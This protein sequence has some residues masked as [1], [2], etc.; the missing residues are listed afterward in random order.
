MSISKIPSMVAFPLGAKSN[1]LLYFDVSSDP[2]PVD[3]KASYVEME[4]SVSNLGDAGYHNLVIG[5]DG[6]MY[7][8]GSAFFRQAKLTDSAR[9]KIQ[10]LNFV[11]VLSENLSHYQKSANEVV[12]DSVFSGVG[13]RAPT[14][15][16]LSVFNNSYADQS[17]VI[18]ATLS[19]LYP[20]TVGNS[21]VM[22]Q[23]GDMEFRYLLE[24]SM[25]LLMRA[26][27]AGVYEGDVSG[28]IAYDFA[29][30]AGNGTVFD[31][32]ITGV[33]T[34]IA[35]GNFVEVSYSTD[36]GD[37]IDTQVRK[38]AN[39]AGFSGSTPQAITLDLALEATAEPALT[40]ISMKI[41]S[42]SHKI[43][44]NALTTTGANS[45]LTLSTGVNLA[46]NTD[47]NVGTKCHIHYHVYNTSTGSLSDEIVE[48]K[49]LSTVNAPDA[50]VVS[51]VLDSPI[52]VSANTDAVFVS[53]VP[54]YQNLPNAE[55]SV[56]GA[57][58]V[59]YRR[60]IKPQK[61]SKLLVGN[62]ESTS[63]Q[64]VDGLN[65]FLYTYKIKP[66]CFNAYVMTPSPT[67]LVAQRQGIKE[68]LMS[69]DNVPLTSIY[70][71]STDSSV[72]QDN[73]VRVFQNCQ[74]GSVK[75]QNLRANRDREVTTEV[76]VCL[77]PAKVFSSM[78]AG[79]PNLQEE[80]Q[81]DRDLTVE[82]L[83]ESVT[84]KTNVFIFMEKWDEL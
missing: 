22:P 58:L 83:P 24:P 36:A 3:M 40:D 55:W 15:E 16:V 67:C 76:E 54:L 64:M 73:I 4:M 10:D 79:E 75:L 53:I 19:S 47:L 41:L 37:T 74:N 44:C 50:V 70:V 9:G 28:G 43:K 32:G 12:A 7:S 65:R 60:N 72:H 82:L 78:V 26:I 29:G 35:V 81:R 49:T 11:N 42:D 71:D 39:V 63:I 13:H 17:P 27:P 48:T 23:E 84:P 68:Y 2:R 66:N 14:G 45:T 69:V 30:E 61:A 56:T 77:Y 33:N 21:Q 34:P 18:R 38:V 31:L 25:P 51:V 80:N 5:Q 20:G 1:N 57:H 62:F 46:K 6:I 8:S 52:T 59:L